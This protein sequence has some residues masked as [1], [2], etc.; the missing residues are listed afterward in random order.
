M[1]GGYF[2]TSWNREKTLRSWWVEWEGRGA[3]ENSTIVA[4]ATTS[5]MPKEQQQRGFLVTGGGT[6]CIRRT[7]RVCIAVLHGRSGIGGGGMGEY[8]NV[9]GILGARGVGT[10]SG[11]ED[12]PSQKGGKKR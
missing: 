8:V 6:D 11:G 12:V 10:R 9:S 4:V 1:P 2:G 7:F 3:L 5:T